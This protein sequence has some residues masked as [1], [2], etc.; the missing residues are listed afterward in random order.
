MTAQM[1]SRHSMVFKHSFG[2]KPGLRL[3]PGH[4]EVGEFSSL[5]CHVQSELARPRSGLRS[6]GAGD[7]DL[8]F[9]SL[10]SEGEHRL[11]GEEDSICS[12]LLMTK[13]FP[14]PRHHHGRLTIASRDVVTVNGRD[15]NNN[16]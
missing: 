14:G 1:Q 6:P 15:T 8:N 9:D 3:G 13:L 11:R 5:P 4:S 7:T 2:F 16:G 12:E 10:K